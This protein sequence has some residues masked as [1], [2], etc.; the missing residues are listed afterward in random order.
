MTVRRYSKDLKRGKHAR[1]HRWLTVI[2][3]REKPVALSLLIRKDCRIFL[4][5]KN[6]GC[7]SFLLIF[8]LGTVNGNRV[9]GKRAV[10]GDRRE[11][12]RGKDS[13][14]SGQHHSIRLAEVPGLDHGVRCERIPEEVP[15]G[16][17]LYQ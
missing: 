6:N 13:I 10:E 4:H 16:V 7:I 1:S 11:N 15:G 9:C 14:R 5:K 8:V 17:R 3:P 12:W 2:S